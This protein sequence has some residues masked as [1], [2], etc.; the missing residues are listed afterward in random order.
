MAVVLCSDIEISSDTF[1]RAARG[2][3]VSRLGFFLIVSL[4]FLIVLMIKN[5]VCITDMIG[6]PFDNLKCRMGIFKLFKSGLYF[7]LNLSARQFYCE[8]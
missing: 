5:Y 8:A 4:V 6:T 2:Y 3:G 1:H 7:F